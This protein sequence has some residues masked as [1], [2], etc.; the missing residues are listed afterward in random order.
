MG[1]IIRV[2]RASITRKVWLVERIK[3]LASVF[4]IDLCAYA[5]MSNHYHLVLFINQDALN[6]WSDEEV[7]D[8]WGSLF[9]ASK[10]KIK[11]LLNYR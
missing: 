8:R 9:P 7:M 2:G 4:A 6:S 1:K 3:F 11:N 10:L 5:I